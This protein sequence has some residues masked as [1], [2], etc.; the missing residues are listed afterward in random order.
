MGSKLPLLGPDNPLGSLSAVLLLNIGAS[1]VAVAAAYGLWRLA[2]PESDRKSRRER[3]A[4]HRRKDQDDVTLGEWFGSHTEIVYPP[5]LHNMGNTCFMNSVLQSLSSLPSLCIYLSERCLHSS[6]AAAS[7]YLDHPSV[8]VTEALLDVCMQLNRLTARR[9]SFKPTSIATAISAT[10]KSNRRLLCYEQQ[11]AHELLQL[12]SSS[13]SSEESQPPTTSP[14]DVNAFEPDG[15]SIVYCGR[16]LPVPSRAGPRN[17]LTGLLASRITCRTCHYTPGIRHHTFHNISLAVPSQRQCMLEDLLAAYVT[18][19]SILDY[20]CDKCSLMATMKKLERESESQQAVIDQIKATRKKV[21][22]RLRKL[23]TST[24]SQ[25]ASTADNVPNRPDHEGSSVQQVDA[26]EKKYTKLES[27]LR[28]ELVRLVV[29]KRDYE[30]VVYASQHNVEADLPASVKRV[31]YAS[32]LSSKEVL[33]ASP[34]PCLTLHMQR[35]VFHPSG[36][37]LK[38]NCRIIFEEYLDLGHFVTTG[39]DGRYFGTGTTQTT[40]DSRVHIHRAVENILDREAARADECP[41]PVEPAEGHA[42]YVTSSLS[43]ASTS[44]DMVATVSVNGVHCAASGHIPDVLTDDSQKLTAKQLQNGG[45]QHNPNRTDDQ[46][47]LPQ[48]RSGNTDGAVTDSGKSF[49]SMADDSTQAEIACETEQAKRR[50]LAESVMERDETSHQTMSAPDVPAQAELTKQDSDAIPPYPYLYRLQS[51]VLH[52]G[53][54]DSGHFATYRRIKH[55]T[56]ERWYRVSDDRV[57]LVNWQEVVAH[58]SQYAY[59]LFYEKHVT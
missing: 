53:G 55:G 40:W 35:S 48:G 49:E 3:K 12:I 31:K 23:Q 57:D 11:D 54:H 39:D 17:P 18:P 32:P 9:Y 30:A 47:G 24:K 16:R 56:V 10:N 25:D 6:N 1:L 46:P 13:I 19:E 38:N 14:L 26:I 45:I 44:D 29:L 41:P 58:G 5:G 52:Y 36:A 8:P 4:L 7:N 51:V 22:R 20:I 37:M 43:T 34:P 33:I 42:L 2:G 28:E 59:M 21:A 15:S 50:G 27:S